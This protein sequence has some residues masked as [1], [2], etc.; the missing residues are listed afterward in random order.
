MAEYVPYSVTLPATIAHPMPSSSGFS[1]TKNSKLLEV[2]KKPTMLK[3]TPVDLSC[4]FSMGFVSV[5]F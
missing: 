5:S 3:M 4:A 1:V 2:I